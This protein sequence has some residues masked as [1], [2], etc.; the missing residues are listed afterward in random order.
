MKSPLLQNCFDCLWGTHVAEMEPAPGCIELADISYGMGLT[1][2]TS[3]VIV[4]SQGFRDS[5]VP[6]SS[7]WIVARP[8]NAMDCLEGF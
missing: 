7:A 5:N 3:V 1:P 2:G 4:L 6:T 8:S